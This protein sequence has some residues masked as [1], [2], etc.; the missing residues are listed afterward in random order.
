LGP[1]MA[2][3]IVSMASPRGRGYMRG[4]QRRAVWQK[5]GQPK[6]STLWNAHREAH[7]K[8]S[9]AKSCEPPPQGQLKGMGDNGSRFGEKD[10]R[11]LD[12]MRWAITVQVR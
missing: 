4:P 1:V 3:R 12:V 8:G 6:N 7:D 10:L 11:L 9:C 5:L 2:H